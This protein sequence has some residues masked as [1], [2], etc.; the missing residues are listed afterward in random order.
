MIAET[1]S[2]KNFWAFIFLFSTIPSKDIQVPAAALKKKVVVVI[3]TGQVVCGGPSGS[4][5]NYADC[6]HQLISE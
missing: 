2:E 5:Q 1:V 3:W 4:Q 6:V